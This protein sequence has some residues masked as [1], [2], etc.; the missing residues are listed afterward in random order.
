VNSAFGLSLNEGLSVWE[1]ATRN[2]LGVPLGSGK[3]ANGR[4]LTRDKIRLPQLE[5]PRLVFLQFLKSLRQ[6]FLR[7]VG[8]G[9][10]CRRRV[11]QKAQQLRYSLVFRSFVHFQLSLNCVCAIIIYSVAI[12]VV[13]VHK[14][15]KHYYSFFFNGFL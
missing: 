11:I 2:L 12:D 3:S 15:I 1:A 7:T 5:L 8:D 6:Q 4:P 10:P 9:M 14:Y 13:L